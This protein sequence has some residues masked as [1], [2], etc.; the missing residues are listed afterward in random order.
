MQQAVP[1]VTSFP[2]PNRTMSLED[3]ISVSDHL[4]DILYEESEYL[5][6]MQLSK[7]IPLHEEK[8]RLT[9]QLESYQRL[10]EENPDILRK[11]DAKTL[12]HFRAVSDEF[13]AIMKENFRLNAVARTVNQRVVQAISDAMFE[14]QRIG[15]YNRQGTTSMTGDGPL[16]YFLSKVYG[17]KWFSSD[18]EMESGC[19]ITPI[20]YKN[21]SLVHAL[22][23]AI[24]LE[25]YLLVEDPWRVVMST[26]HPNGGSFLAYPQIIRLLMDCTYRRD[27]LKTCHPMVRERSTLWD[28]DREYTL[29][30]IA[31]ITR[32]GPA[33]ILGLKDKGHLGPG[34]DADIT[35][36]TPH[37]NKEIMF[38][39]PRVVIK[40][41]QVIVEQ[42]EI[43]H[44]PI[45]KTLHVD[46]VYDH[47]VE[48]DIQQWFE[49]YYSI[50]WR[51]Y[52]V[53]ISYLHESAVVPP[54]V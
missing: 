48:P 30:E 49:K 35:I 39:M 8:L 22:Q 16:G 26:D 23:W 31:I 10:L 40:A 18:T 37:E 12:E 27:I 5:R 19:G 17:G 20:K 42:G 45:G 54:R 44:T 2:L 43:R 36:Y 21:K 28:L 11:A 32:A 33:R 1:Q 24:G 50:R 46:P 53:D 47:E 4:A 9:H 7:I 14:T 15:S 6:T 3:L 51:N 38:E 52:P 25:W 29:N 13:T 34:A 41:G